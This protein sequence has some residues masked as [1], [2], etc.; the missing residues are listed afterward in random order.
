MSIRRP[1]VPRANSP[2]GTA[3]TTDPLGPSPTFMASAGTGGPI[4]RARADSYAGHSGVRANPAG[5][6]GRLSSEEPAAADET[7]GH[8]A[9]EPWHPVAIENFEKMVPYV[10]GKIHNRQDVLVYSTEP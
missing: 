5:G 2:P 9:Y 8:Y 10:R 6:D 1:P 3:A 4:K 7:P